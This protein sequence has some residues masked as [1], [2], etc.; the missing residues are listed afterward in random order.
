MSFSLPG[1]PTGSIL[2]IRREHDHVA[3]RADD[4]EIVRNE[5]DRSDVANRM[6]VAVA[7]EWTRYATLGF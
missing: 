4:L 1:T 3:P 6:P 7:V 5:F 2:P